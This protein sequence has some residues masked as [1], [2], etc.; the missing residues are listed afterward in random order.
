MVMMMTFL[1]LTV[2]EWECQ[3]RRRQ[4]A[5]A[6]RGVAQLFTRDDYTPA[7]PPHATHGEITFQS[8]DHKFLMG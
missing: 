8:A 7:T 1:T 3:R 6:I 4:A 2:L 5:I